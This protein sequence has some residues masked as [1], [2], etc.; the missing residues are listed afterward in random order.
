MAADFC[1]VGQFHGGD[2]PVAENLR[3]ASFEHQRQG[4]FAELAEQP[5]H[6]FQRRGRRQARQQ[7]T[8]TPQRTP[9]FVSSTQSKWNSRKKP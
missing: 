6:D 9:Q 8:S 1:R 3:I 5:R 7:T 4:R 2:E